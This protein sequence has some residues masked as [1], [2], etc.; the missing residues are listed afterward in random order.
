VDSSPLLRNVD[1]DPLLRNIE[2]Q[3]FQIHSSQLS[4]NIIK[5]SENFNLFYINKVK[6]IFKMLTYNLL[7]IWQNNSDCGLCRWQYHHRI[8]GY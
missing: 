6:S 4:L 2:S 3:L 5:V 1:S 8:N 7:I